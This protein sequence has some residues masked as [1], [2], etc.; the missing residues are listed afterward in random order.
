MARRRFFVNDV[1]A[2]R[3]Q[4]LGED[5]HHL[6]RVL[7]VEPGQK[8]EISD[9]RNLYLAEIE[10]VRNDLVSF[11]VIEPLAPAEP[12]VSV[13]LFASLIK[14]DRFEWLLEKA[15][16]LGVD[17][18]T[19]VMAERSEKGLDRAAVKRIARWRKNVR[20]A[21]EQS[22]RAHLPELRPPMLLFEAASQSANRR[23]V[24]DE[25]PLAPPLLSE[26][27]LSRNQQDRIALLVGPEGGW[28]ERERASLVKSA[29]VPVGLGSTIL[30]AETAAIAAIAI[31]NAAWQTASR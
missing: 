28:T 29:W 2:G 9:N 6:T 15:T 5:A 16:E 8:Y 26:I 10:T 18:I 13:S 12:A 14:F 31:I 30:R 23:Y 3:A 21:S 17:A 24:L 11:T 22:R 1:Q 27:P 20:E 19:P 4:I 7:R 25:H